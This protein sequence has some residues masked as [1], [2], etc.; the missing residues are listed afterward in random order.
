MP[1]KLLDYGLYQVYKTLGVVGTS[2]DVV[3]NDKQ[4]IITIGVPGLLRNDIDITIR[5]G[6]R[7]IIKSKRSSKFTPEFSYIFII[8][9]VVIRDETYATVK[10]GILSVFIKKAEHGDYRIKMK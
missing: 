1:L 5:E 8:P 9:C 6:K 7:M 4:F 3:E 10:D 2:Y